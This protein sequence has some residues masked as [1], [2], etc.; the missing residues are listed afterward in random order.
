[1]DNENIQNQYIQQGQVIERKPGLLFVIR[2]DDGREL[3]NCYISHAD[4][5][6]RTKIEALVPKVGERIWVKE[7]PYNPGQAR[8]LINKK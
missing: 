6:R 7:S 3:S 5:G 8:I 4:I 2:L 1:M